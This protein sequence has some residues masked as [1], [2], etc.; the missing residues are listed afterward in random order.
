MLDYVNLN[1]SEIV[2]PVKV[3]VYEELL[4]Q[5]GYNKTKT[6]Y[7]VQGF[8]NGFS[9]E[10]KGP[11]K[12]CRTARNLP[13]RVGNKFEL[14]N[15]VM[16]EVKAERYAGPFEEIPFKNYIQSPIGLVP[17]DKGTKTRLIFHLSHP[18]KGD[19]VNSGIP[20]EM[21]SVEYPDFM[22]ALKICIKAG[23]GCSCAK[24]DMSMAFRNVPMDKES[25]RYLVLKCEHPV[26]GKVYYFVDKCLPFGASISCAIFQEFSNSVAFL[27]KYRTNKPLVNYLDDYFFAALRKLLCDSQV[28]EFLDICQ[29]ICFPVSL[30]KT[31][32]GITWLVFLGLLIDT[33][34]QLICIPADKI[35]RA[36]DMIEYFLNKRNQKVT[37][38]Q[39][40]KLAGFLNFVCKAVVPGRAF[41]RRL[42]GLI[43]SEDKLMQ[44]HHVRVS[45][46]V[47]L[48]LEIWRTFLTNP[49]VFCRPFM[50]AIKR[51]AKDINMYS[52]ASG[53]V[54]KGAGAYC[55]MAWTVCQWDRS[56]MEQEQ[57]S[58]EYLELYGVTIGVL[59]WINK[60]KNS[61]VML[62]CDNSSVCAMINNSSTSCRHCMVLIRII[63][64]ECMVQNVHLT[65]EWLSTK[66]NGKADALSRL[67]FKRFRKLAKGKMNVMPEKLP[68]QIWPVQKIWLKENQ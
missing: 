8:R 11:K 10:Y 3:R 2:T 35:D 64:L 52:D 21:C 32:W 61:S 56:W 22:D 68:T 29:M 7:L 63:V 57:P 43:V 5:A 36:L 13:L 47:R 54:N 42:Y 40:Q 62:H 33:V 15:K 18:K 37:V 9:L 12:V 34:N 51:T 65:A 25:W 4:K 30:E 41:V 17:K 6:E 16:K 26:T 1:L 38:L 14:W 45:E 49:Q 66:D 31:V 28:S 53:S 27:V 50:H 44:H 60:F 23:K 46:E 19:S 55:G 24:S 20:E 58:I 48:D 67:E 39:I 59:L